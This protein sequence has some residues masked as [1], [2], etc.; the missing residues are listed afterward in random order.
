[1]ISRLIMISFIAAVAGCLN[2]IA[3]LTRTQKP[4]SYVGTIS[5][6]TPFIKQQSFIVP[7]QYSGGEWAMNSGLV[8][9]SVDVRVVERLIEF[10]V[11]VALSRAEAHETGY[12]LKLPK[13][14][15][16]LYQLV[17]RDPSGALHNLRA[18]DLK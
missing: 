16:G 13:T 4:L 15:S 10:T 2:P 8:P 11:V 18:I 12:Q 5:F 1:M 17:Y 3:S 9:H 14:L 7:L 6:G